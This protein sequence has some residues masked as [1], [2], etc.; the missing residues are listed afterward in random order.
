LFALERLL[1]FLFSST[2]F[3]VVSL[4]NLNTKQHYHY[5][6]NYNLQNFNL[7]QTRMWL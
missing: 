2:R 4:H 1:F 7:T 3:I 5:Q 6:G